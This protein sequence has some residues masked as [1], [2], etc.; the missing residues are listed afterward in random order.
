MEG[1]G[2]YAVHLPFLAPSV[3][4]ESLLPPVGDAKSLACAR[5]S[6]HSTGTV[7]ALTSV[8]SQTK[9]CEYEMEGQGRLPVPMLSTPLISCA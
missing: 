8:A 6:C 3:S 2:T 4:V 1:Q 5:N 7:V 9:R